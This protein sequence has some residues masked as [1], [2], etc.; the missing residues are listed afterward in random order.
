MT[1]TFPENA[2]TVLLTEG[3]AVDPDIVAKIRRQLT[4]GGNAVITSGL[5]SAQQDKG[6]DSL[7]C[8]SSRTPTACSGSRVSRPVG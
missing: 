3:A 4:G 1:P 7:P 5:L 6:I 8:G 2:P